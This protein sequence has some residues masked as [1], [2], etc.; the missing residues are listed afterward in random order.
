M[1][2]VCAVDFT[3]YHFLR[4]LFHVA[5]DSGWTVEFACAD[6]PLAAR[7]RDEG[8]HYRPESHTRR[9]SPSTVRNPYVTRAA[10][11]ATLAPIVLIRAG[12]LPCSRA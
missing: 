3:A 9:S 1:L 7:L 6:D 11:L 8:F 2:Q 4:P 5:R 10:R 12:Q